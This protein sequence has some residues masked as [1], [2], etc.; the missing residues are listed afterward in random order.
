MGKDNP[1]LGGMANEFVRGIGIITLGRLGRFLFLEP[2]TVNRLPRR[3]S[4]ERRVSSGFVTR[5]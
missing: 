2:F 5:D 4:M 3:W 1:G